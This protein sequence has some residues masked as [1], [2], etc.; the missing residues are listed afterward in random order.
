VS[1]WACSFLVLRLLPL[2]LLFAVFVLSDAPADAGAEFVESVDG[3]VWARG[4]VAGVAE[5][6]EAVVGVAAEVAAELAGVAAFCV[7]D[8]VVDIALVGG[9]VAPRGVLAV[10][11]ADLDGTAQGAA[12][13][14]LPA[15]REDGGV[16]GEQDGFEHRGVEVGHEV[17]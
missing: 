14:A 15:D 12:E 17:A 13:G 1:W 4:V 9:D 7:G 3:A 2:S 5:V 16:V 8:D 11:V 6:G 10:L